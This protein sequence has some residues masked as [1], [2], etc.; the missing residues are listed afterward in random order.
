MWE[1]LLMV[2]PYADVNTASQIN[3]GLD[4]INVL[5]SFHAVAAPPLLIT[6]RGSGDPDDKF[7]NYKSSCNVGQNL[8]VKVVLAMKS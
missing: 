4:I 8:T 6:E 7:P 5:S 1:P 2:F 3:A